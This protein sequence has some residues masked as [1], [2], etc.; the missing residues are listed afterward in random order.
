MYHVR[1]VQSAST[2]PCTNVNPVQTISLPR[3]DRPT[4]AAVLG[5]ELRAGTDWLRCGA[6]QFAV[7]C[8]DILGAVEKAF[9]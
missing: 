2:S 1:Q 6:S 7:A 3:R 4:A 9:A 8:V 5:P